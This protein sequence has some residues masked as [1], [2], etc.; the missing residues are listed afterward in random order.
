MIF[1]HREKFI[2]RLIKIIFLLIPFSY[3]FSTLKAA[4]NMRVKLLNYM[5]DFHDKQINLTSKPGENIVF[6]KIKDKSTVFHL[7]KY[8]K[9]IKLS[10]ILFLRIL[11]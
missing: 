2:I 4:Q 10:L 8:L 1:P 11:N 3:S 7:L 9:V 6:G 5:K